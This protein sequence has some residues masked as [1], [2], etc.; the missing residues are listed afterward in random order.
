MH[1]A[2]PS[3]RR[4][5]SLM[6]TKV[7][8]TTHLEDPL[9]PVAEMMFRSGL[10]EVAVVDQDRALLGTL[11][12]TDIVRGPGYGADSAE[13]FLGRQQLRGAVTCELDDAF[14][15]AVQAQ[16]TVGDVMTRSPI[17]VKAEATASEAAALMHEHQL[18]QLP[19]VDA[20]GAFLG[21]VT[22]LDLAK[23]LH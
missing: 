12:R 4:I 9:A 7:L 11:S 16:V 14:R 13:V 1:T 8:M 3:R 19:V 6:N 20:R 18:Q 17:R 21:M 22:A 5:S 15:L 2:T 23:L 10:G